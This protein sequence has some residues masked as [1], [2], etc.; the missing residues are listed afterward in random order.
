MNFK[1]R[2]HEENY[3]KI[4]HYNQINQTND[5]EKILKEARDKK[6]CSIQRNKHKGYCCDLSSETMQAR[7]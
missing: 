1:C 2:K 4:V 3:T 7:R 6:T 5:K